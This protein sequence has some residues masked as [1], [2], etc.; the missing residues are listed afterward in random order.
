M[1]HHAMN[2]KEIVISIR[3]AWVVSNASPV[4]MAVSSPFLGVSAWVH[5][6]WIIAMIQILQLYSLSQQQSTLQRHLLK[7]RGAVLKYARA[8]GVG[9]FAG[10]QEIIVNSPLVKNRRSFLGRCRRLSRPIVASVLIKS[11]MT[12][13]TQN[14]ALL[15]IMASVMGW[16]FAFKTLIAAYPRRRLQLWLRLRPNPAMISV[17]TFYQ[18]NGVQKNPICPVA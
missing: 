11:M 8:R 13:I 3:T 9:S 2:A 15:V 6:E 10:I 7:R 5:Q 17:W 4:V 14:H 18:A 12:A 16:R 1:M